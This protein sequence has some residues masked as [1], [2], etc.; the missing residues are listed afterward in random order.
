M[1]HPPLQP[2]R[3]RWLLL[4]L[5]GVQFTHIVDF[6]I[7]MPLGPQ[8]TRLF[9]ISDAQFGL[10]VSAYTLAAGVSGLA[11]STYLDRFG[12]KRLLLTLYGLF[13]LS[14][15]ACGLAP[16][17]GSLMAA[18]VAA[19][20][21]GGVLAAL[22]Q[23]IVADVIP[24]GRRG[25][26]MAIVMSAF[27]V[28]TVAGV[29][30]G[31]WLASVGGWHLPFLTLAALSAL[32]ALAGLA[33]LPA[34]AGH[35]ESGRAQSPWRS[36]GRVLAERNHRRAFTFSAL[37]MFAGF[38]VIPYLTIFM[39]TN[40]GLTDQQVPLIYLCGGLATLVTARLFG[41]LSDQRGKVPVFRA[42]ALAML[43]PLVAITLLRPL[44]LWAVLVVTTT[45][46][47]CMSGRMI[48]GMAIVT[49]AAEPGLRGTF[50]ALNSAVQS[51]AIGV[52]AFVGGLIIGRDAQGLV[53]HYPL[54]ALVG[55]AAAL[56]SLVA[57]RRLHLH[58]GTPPGAAPA[59][60]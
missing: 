58:G 50:M 20:T 53:Q 11:A 56:A 9:G 37:M 54:S 47:I 57:V 14:T 8:L 16:G 39:Q 10:L 25:R 34:L 33:T 5:A 22:V 55:V 44:P 1:T 26:A 29:P 28:A 23:T 45:L 30:G 40:V 36:I 38:T 43:A 60:P 46:F 21:F 3:E 32:L 42:L 51:A 6:M 13:A 15:L 18:R 35:V 12:R 17:Y 48:P 41:R 27:S 52:A 59:R 7:M 4:T 49:S 2:R 31:L 19:G 24:F